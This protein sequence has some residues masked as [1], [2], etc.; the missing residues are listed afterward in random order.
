MDDDNN[1]GAEKY[2]ELRLHNGQRS[3]CRQPWVREAR[4]QGKEGQELAH[5]SGSQEVVSR[6]RKVVLVMSVVRIVH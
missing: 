1:L 6:M 2:P 5:L 3:W 4:R